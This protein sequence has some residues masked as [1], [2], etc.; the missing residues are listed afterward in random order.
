MFTL[1]QARVLFELGLS[2]CRTRCGYLA[3][4]VGG[5]RARPIKIRLRKLNSA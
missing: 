5:D 2:D 4:D 3:I 1:R